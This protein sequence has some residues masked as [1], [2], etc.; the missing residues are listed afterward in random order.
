MTSKEIMRSKI[1]VVSARDLDPGDFIHPTCA[2][3][4]GGLVLKVE[5]RPMS[6]T[7]DMNIFVHGRK[8]PILADA[9]DHFNVTKG[10][11]T[12]EALD[13]V[14]EEFE[15]LGRDRKGVA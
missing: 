14:V 15:T 3:A 9:I 5:G 4:Q 6:I 11:L 7:P 1:Q 12:G 13:A 2:S 8:T 10:L